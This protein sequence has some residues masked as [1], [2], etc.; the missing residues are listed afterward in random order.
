MIT[1]IRC[2]HPSQFKVI[3]ILLTISPILYIAFLWF[4]CF[5]TGSFLPLNPLHL[6]FPFLHPPSPWQTLVYSLPMTFCFV[7]FTLL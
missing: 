5:K 2:Y 6:F 3:T 7:C 1:M 4:T